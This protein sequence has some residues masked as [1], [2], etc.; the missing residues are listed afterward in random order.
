MPSF[1]WTSFCISLMMSAKKRV[2]ACT[3]RR[4]IVSKMF[5]C[6]RVLLTVH[7]IE[8]SVELHDELRWEGCRFSSSASVA[9]SEGLICSSAHMPRKRSKYFNDSLNR[10]R[11]FINATTSALCRRWGFVEGLEVDEARR[12]WD[13]EQILTLVSSRPVQTK[14][15]SRRLDL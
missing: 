15:S 3:E 10:W 1:S 8:R 2:H 6:C 9:G 4:H 11:V 7:R 14:L 12:V 13:F 5:S